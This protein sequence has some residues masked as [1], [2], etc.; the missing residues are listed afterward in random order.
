MKILIVRVTLVEASGKRKG[1]QTKIIKM[2][3]VFQGRHSQSERKLD[4]TGF[5]TPVTGDATRHHRSK[6]DAEL[7]KGA[8]R[9]LY[10]QRV[11]KEMRGGSGGESAERQE[12]VVR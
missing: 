8:E 5:A 3:A 9:N 1:K 12:A 11:I 2:A 7:T 10:L 4:N 6:I